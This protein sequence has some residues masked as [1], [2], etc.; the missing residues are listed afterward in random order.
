[1][2]ATHPHFTGPETE[3]QRGSPVSP[4]LYTRQHLPSPWSR[5]QEPCEIGKA[6]FVSRKPRFR[7][8]LLFP[9]PP[10]L[11][12]PLQGPDPPVRK[13]MLRSLQNLPSSPSLATQ[14]PIKPYLSWSPILRGPISNQLSQWFN[15]LLLASYTCMFLEVPPRSKRRVLMVTSQDKTQEDLFSPF[16][17][18][19]EDVISTG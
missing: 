7:I 17:H 4:L 13:L 10:S 14:T 11:L 9:E 6:P 15:M 2:I 16:K 12:P 18:Q 1:M 5:Y 3:A 8:D 19:L